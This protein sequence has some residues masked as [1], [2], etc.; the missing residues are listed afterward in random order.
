MDK[1]WIKFYEDSDPHLG[2]NI[3]PLA[4]DERINKS[5]Y[6]MM[7]RYLDKEVLGKSIKVTGIH[8][9]SKIAL[10]LTTDDHM[11][12]SASALNLKQ[13]LNK[14]L[15]KTSTVKIKSSKESN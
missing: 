2:I 7:R 10:N 9:Q 13:I 12:D 11:F 14:D 8:K 15:N 1:K 3:F 4:K 6:R 5:P